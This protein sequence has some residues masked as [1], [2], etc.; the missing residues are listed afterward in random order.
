MPH[1]IRRSRWLTATGLLLALLLTLFNRAYDPRAGAQDAGLAPVSIDLTAA[2]STPGDDVVNVAG[3]DIATVTLTLTGVKDACPPTVNTKPVDVVLVIDISGSMSNPTSDGITKLDATKV[4]AMTFLDQ[5]KL[6]SPDATRPELADQ[7][8]LVVFESNARQVI[9]LTRDRSALTAAIQ[10]LSPTGGT[11]IGDGIR[12]AVDILA[13]PDHNVAGGALPVIV[14]LSDG[15]DSSGE[16]E[17]EAARAHRVLETNTKIAAIGLGVDVKR[18][19]LERI[20]D[21]DLV[22]FTNDSAAL[23]QAYQDI[24]R[25]IQTH[26][27]ASNLTITYTYDRAFYELQPDSL[28]PA[29]RVEGNLIIWPYEKLE[30]GD[31]ISFSF[32]VRA[33]TAGPYPVGSVQVEYF[34][35]EQQIPRSDMATG[36]TIN[37]LQPSPT[38][39]PTST[40]TPTLAPTPLPTMTPLPPGAA[41]QGPD[42]TIDA[43]GVNY[44]YCDEGW[45][46]WLPWLIALLLLLL[47][48]F[49]LWRVAR[50][51]EKGFFESFRN[52][53]CFLIFALLLLWLVAL[54]FLLLRPLIGSLCETPESVYFWRMDSSTEGIFL[55]H[56]E[57]RSDQPAQVQSLNEQG[58]VGCHV[59][60]SRAKLVAATGGPV[61]GPVYITTFD[62]KLVDIPHITAV[63]LAFSPD[64]KKLAFSDQNADLQILD[65]DSGQFAPLSGASDPAYGELM[66]AWSA[67]GNTIAFARAPITQVSYSLD[68]T[69][70]CGIYV[71]PAAGGTPQPLPGASE[72]GFNYYPSYSPDGKWLAFTHHTNDHTYSDPAADV[73]LVPATGGLARP[74]EGNSEV[75]DSWATWSRDSKLLAFNTT[76]RDQNFDIVVVDVSDDGSTSAPRSLRGASQPGVFE[77]LPFWGDPIDKVNVF[78]EWKSL[79]WWLFVVPL[80]LF[81]AWLLC[82][83]WPRKREEEKEE[84]PEPPP[85]GPVVLGP[86][87][88][89]PWNGIDVLWDPQPALVIGLGR[90]GRWT[91]THLKKTLK[92]ANLGHAP[93]KVA[94]LCIAAGDD[95]VL[96]QGDVPSAF[97]FGGVELDGHEIIEWR[98]NLQSLVQG[99]DHDNALR[100][101]MRPDY[102]NRLGPAAKDPT[103]GLQERRVLGRLALIGNLRGQS[104]DTGKQVWQELQKAAQRATKSDGR[105]TVLIVADLSDAVGSGSVLDVAYLV[106]RLE[107]RLKLHGVEIVAHL[108]THQ[109]QR[110]GEHSPQVNTAAA[111]R[112]L[113]RFQLASNSVPFPMR[114]SADARQPLGEFDGVLNNL[115]FDEMYLYDKPYNYDKERHPK[116]VE[117]APAENGIYPAVADSIAVW[118]DTAAQSGN[119]SAQ[120]DQMSGMKSQAGLYRRQVMYSSL[121]LYQYRLPFADL[122]ETIT[123]KYARQALQHLLMA[124]SAADPVLNAAQAYDVLIEGNDQ[125]P[126]ALVSA[127]LNERL[128]QLQNMNSWRLFLQKMPKRRRQEFQPEA[129]RSALGRV[130]VQD[131][132]QASLRAWLHQALLLILNGRQVA[133]NQEPNYIQSRGAKVGLA[134]EFLIELAGDERHGGLLQTWVEHL[135][136]L[137][138]GQSAVAAQFSE[139]A[140][141]ARTLQANLKKVAEGLGAPPGK[142]SLHRELAKREGQ[143]DTSQQ[144]LANLVTREYLWTDA[145]GNPLKDAWYEDYLVKNIPSVLGRIQW[146]TNGDQVVLTL[147]KPQLET[148]RGD[149]QEVVFDPANIQP[150]ED[151]LLEMGRYFAQEV[152]TRV[153]LADIL[154]QKLLHRDNITATARTLLDKSSP[155]LDARAGKADTQVP[156]LIVSANQNIHETDLVG[157]VIAER[158]QIITPVILNTTDP[159]SLTLIQTVDIVPR[160]AIR[161]LEAAR[162]QYEIETGLSGGVYQKNSAMLTSVFEAEENALFFERQFRERDNAEFEVHFLQELV[163]RLGVQR[164]PDS[165]TSRKMLMPVTVALLSEQVK[166]EVFLLA[167]ASGTEAVRAKGSLRFNA[168]EWPDKELVAPQEN[169]QPIIEGMLRFRDQID[170]ET[171]RKI[172]DRYDRDAALLGL[173]NDW[174]V[175]KTYLTWMDQ[176]T[177]EDDQAVIKDL[178]L[179]T[180]LLIE[181]LFPDE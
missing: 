17:D 66:P 135:K 110:K 23:I 51:R 130:K 86:M 137:D 19:T 105:L 2:S 32:D 112:E 38:P 39:L 72:T 68:I 175:N 37:T 150:F 77:H 82:H 76:A 91:L 133:A 75:S 128:G 87:K 35:C 13:G 15:N 121:G 123:V 74:I 100:G 50:S 166:A 70:S 63:Y 27:N 178:I 149:G 57:L 181:A 144:Q 33:T 153:T 111:I 172:R 21:P 126:A 81:L 30:E 84:E 127:F 36:P 46:D 180:R 117:N 12:G 158:T 59:V 173:W 139:L 102:L 45:W 104:Q 165:L 107:D 92:D 42:G 9:G 142:N 55:T 119:L 125:S 124:Q 118:L 53:L 40:A 95:A 98:D 129:V 65:I 88:L 10:G 155:A 113:E 62:G 151:A 169:V 154:R 83:F 97:N 52:L 14:L 170:D 177:N 22:Y 8:A 64:G 120:R 93:D 131:Q 80:L 163:A 6:E 48:L 41:L 85:Q 115:I 44:G 164:L 54:L 24:A 179:I 61:P 79:P 145:E 7:A 67:D 1:A 71:I 58:C 136:Q 20:A 141:Y 138:G 176:A 132:D 96:K 168:K 3:K 25:A 28:Q 4:A 103:V 122:L 56:P 109:A 31:S 152:R 148:E 108:I 43:E 161:S 156:G 29:G 26:L 171:A 116:R 140:S 34:P 167:L 60:N 5:L 11:D 49:I 146:R 134:Y 174:I 94:L 78:D 47:V 73:W 159:Y 89:K 18:E 16:A 99:A 162:D 143:F 160:E 69:G 90:A 114:Y 147:I 101:W 106:R 157:R